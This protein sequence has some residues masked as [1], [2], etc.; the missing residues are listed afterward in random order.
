MS[1]KYKEII[2]NLYD[3]LPHAEHANFEDNGEIQ[4]YLLSSF[5][6]FK[7]TI[8]FYPNCF[9]KY[10]IHRF[11][12]YRNFQEDSDLGGVSSDDAQ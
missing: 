11:S 12:P 4:R 6:V 7:L 9:L 1:Q 3:K 10:F 5:N 2:D 8:N